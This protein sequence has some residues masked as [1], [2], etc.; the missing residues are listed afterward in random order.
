MM[1]VQD[2]EECEDDADVKEEEANF[3]SWASIDTLI[4]LSK[5]VALNMKGKKSFL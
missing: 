4:L 3:P 5:M 2:E 1:N